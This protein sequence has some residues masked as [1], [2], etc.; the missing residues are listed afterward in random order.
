MVSAEDLRFFCQTRMSDE[1]LEANR[2]Y[3]LASGL[4]LEKICSGFGSYDK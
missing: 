1:D 2:Q 4:I 3:L